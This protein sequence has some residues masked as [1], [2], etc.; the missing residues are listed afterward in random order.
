MKCYTIGYSDRKLEEFLELLRL[1][2]IDCVIDVRNTPYARNNNRVYDKEIIE[3]QIKQS[4]INYIYMGNQ[5]SIKNV[6]SELKRK[7]KSMNFH[8]ALEDNSFNRGINKILEGIKRGH[9]IVLMCEEKNP[10]NCSRGIFLGYALKKEGIKLEHIITDVMLKNQDRIEEE[11]YITYEP[12]FQDKFVNLTIQDMVEYD[13]YDKVN[14]NYIKERVI[15][16]GY[17][18]KFKEIK[19]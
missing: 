10:F 1:Y 2:N 16:E 7:G 6:H 17:I 4:G 3:K 12:F 18:R 9:T 11:I 5:L 15:E 13:D 8:N 14:L 19:S